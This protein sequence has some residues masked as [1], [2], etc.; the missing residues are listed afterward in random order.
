MTPLHR[1]IL[2]GLPISL[3]LWAIV[4]ALVL[5]GCAARP[6][7]TLAEDGALAGCEESPVQDKPNW[8]EMEWLCF[9]GDCFCGEVQ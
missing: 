2:N 6:C 7:Y 8:C 1:G 4:L 5:T 9:E 3:L